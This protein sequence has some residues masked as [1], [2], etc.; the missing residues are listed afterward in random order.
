MTRVL[1]S[2]GTGFV[3]RFIVEHLLQRGYK[4]AVGGRSEPPAGFFTQPVT[5]VP[6]RLDPDADQVAAFDNVCYFVH[7]A[8]EHVEGK[9]RGGEGTDP[10]GFRR[11]NVD[12]SVRLFEEARTAGVRRC[13][14]L[15]SRAVYGETPSTILHENTP[16]Q[17][18]TLYGVVKLA[19]ED[20]LESMTAPDFVTTS[21]RV[22]GAYGPAGPGRT[23]K[24]SGLF[25]DYL[26]G[27]PVQPRVGTEVYGD[28][29]AASVRLMLENDPAKVS[30][31]VFNVS[32]VLTGN[33]DILSVLQVATDCPN[34]LPPAAE[35]KEF[36]EMSTEK[37][38][39][40]GWLPGGRE[41]LAAT[42]RE[43]AGA[44]AQC[45]VSEPHTP[46]TAPL[47]GFNPRTSPLPA[48]GERG[49]GA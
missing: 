49:P 44:G 47:L 25:A 13:V 4:V 38:R 7:A 33:R 42:I 39:A 29:I 18:D 48:R 30:G 1:V 15:S 17:P 22:T 35:A 26:A 5:Y 16:T 24:W 21:L 19:A 10:E 27:R 23:H 46:V 31:Q 9:Y 8:F 28:D 2:G 40:L 32:D 34:P 20:A 36:K 3:G 12:G 45:N 11:A 43:L 6:L 41:R 37:L 14:F